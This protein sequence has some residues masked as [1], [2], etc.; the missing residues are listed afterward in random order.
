M[1]IDCSNLNPANIHIQMKTNIRTK[2]ILLGATIIGMILSVGTTVFAQTILQTVSQTGA[3]PNWNSAI[4]DTPPTVPN[5]G[6]NY[7]TPNGFSVR[8]PAQ[9]LTGLYNTNFLGNSLQI[10]TGGILQ[11]KHG[12]NLTNAAIV[13]LILNGGTMNFH[14]GYAP[15]PVPV[16]GT[17]QVIADSVITTDQTGANAADIW[18]LSSISGTNNLTVNMLSP[19]ANNVILFGTNT[20]Y[21]GNW[22]NANGGLIIEGSTINALGS[23]SVTLQVADAFLGFNSTNNLVVGN[24]IY[25]NGNVIKWNT[26]TVTL[27]GTNTFSGSLIISNGVIQIGN[28]SAISTAATISLLNGTTLDASSAGGLILN[29]AGQNL[30]C[31][32]TVIGNLTA[33]ASDALNFHLSA[34]TNDILN[35]TGSLTLDGSPVLN[36]LLSGYKA[37]G[38]YRLINYSGTIQGGGSFNLVPPAG[39]TETFQLDT[40]TPGQVNLIVTGTTYNTTWVGDGSANYWDDSSPNWIGTTNVYQDVGDNVT[41]NDSGSGVPDIYVTAPVTPNSMTVSN[42]A[43]YYIFDGSAITTSGA[44]I[45]DGTNELDFTSSG[46]NFSG[47]I[48][49]KAGIL[50]IG[51]GGSTGSL[52]T[53]PIT[54]N[55]VL[56]VNLS[57]GGV[58][59]NAPISGSGSLNIATGGTSVAIG[60]TNSYAG[61][62]TIGSGC[63]LTFTT[64]SALGSGAATIVTG[65]RLGITS[66]VGSMTVTNPVVVS[67]DYV[68][69]GGALYVNTSG[70]NITWSGPITVGAGNDGIVNQIRVVN[71]NTKMNFSNTVLGTNEELECTAGNSDGDNTSVMTF[72]NTISLGSSGSLLVDGLAVVA[73]DGTNTWGGGTTVGYNG[74]S[75]YVTSSTATLLV[76]GKLN[77]GALE[78]ENLATLGGSGTILDSVTVDGTVAPG[79]SG[80]GTLT[81][82]NSVTFESDGAAVMEIN[83]T[84]GQNADLLSATSVAYGGSL[85]VTNIGPNLQAGDTFHLFNGTISGTFAATNL[86]ALFSTNLFWDTSLLN[87]GI[88]K[89]SSNTA[90]TPTITSPSVSGANFTLQVA[91]SQK[92][93]NYVL[94]ATPA[95][96]PATWTNIYTNAGTGG[97]LNFTNLITPGNPQQFFRISVQ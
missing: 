33:S 74:A 21:S 18:V 43:N 4:W 70:N 51:N 59:F 80:I 36:L 53:G 86:P 2:A 87:S 29:P 39:S 69:P 20:A 73:L 52:G 11:L 46:N 72:S 23:G 32:G 3:G 63:Q 96:A 44:L 81:V 37:S 60:A 62:T 90:P 50:S 40:T 31:N 9:N 1:I 57:A 83:R 65:G 61:G 45:K 24:T 64:S 5:N 17:I 27:N 66:A 15:T 35:V 49:I 14:G 56:Q 16:G 22:V 93:F 12:G 77:G 75:P 41:F 67:G 7:E 84:A 54:N 26:N 91:S 19:G 34:A 55:G 85:T 92:G 79:S 76:N 38:T 10:D 28:G 8:T 47:Q 97:T 6:N 82:N 78:V 30:S 89:V 71:V 42:T 68:S 88:I 48:F 95:L 13:N 58:G 25:G 94:Q